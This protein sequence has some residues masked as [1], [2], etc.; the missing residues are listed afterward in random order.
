MSIF[1]FLIP[2][3]EWRIPV[4]ILLGAMAGLTMY[5]LIESKAISYLSDDPKACANCHVMTPQYTTWQNSSH[6]EWA[7]CND[8]HIPQGN[9]I[10][11]Y[12]AKAQD[13]FFHSAIFM[14]RAE[15]EVIEMRAERD[16][17]V[18]NNCIRCH[19][20]QITDAKMSSMSDD[21]IKNATTKNCWECHREVPHGSVNSLSSVKYYGRIDKEHQETVPEWLEKYL[22]NSENKNNK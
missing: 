9:I 5:G 17:T 20:D 8:C 2:P 7:S 4:I 18:Q 3:L 13:G 16:I 14:M 19:K 12:V 6:R 15:P 21:H 11:K 1:K 22:N 10:E